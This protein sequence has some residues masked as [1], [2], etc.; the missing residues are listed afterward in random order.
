LFPKYGAFVIEE[1][2][3]SGDI[4]TPSCRTSSV[5]TEDRTLVIPSEG[6]GNSITTGVKTG[7]LMLLRISVVTGTPSNRTTVIGEESR[8]LAV[9][10]DGSENTVGRLSN[11]FL[12]LF[13]HLA[14]TSTPSNRKL[15]IDADDRTLTIEC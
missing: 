12:L 8:T 6:T 1:T 3:Y 7:L 15:I 5:S 4:E 9:E 13:S 11:G 10:S 2:S 14:V